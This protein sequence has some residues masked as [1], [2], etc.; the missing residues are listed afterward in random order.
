MA[1]ASASAAERLHRDVRG[2]PL[3]ERD[4]RPPG[5]LEVDPTFELWSSGTP[6][7]NS[8]LVGLAR[9]APT[10]TPR[11]RPSAAWSIRAQKRGDPPEVGVPVQ[12]P[13]PGQA[14]QWLSLVPC[15]G[16]SGISRT[17]RPKR[18]IVAAISPIE[19]PHSTSDGV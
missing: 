5:G 10:A 19:M 15:L 18:K 13:F 3:D 1:S 6:A 16:S 2:Q 8:S 17:P 12:P 9:R 11:P 7:R 4:H 14:T